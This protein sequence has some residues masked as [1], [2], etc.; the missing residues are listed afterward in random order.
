MTSV[1]GHCPMGSDDH[2]FVPQ[3]DLN[4]FI[5]LLACQVRADFCIIHSSARKRLPL[6]EVTQSKTGSN[7]DIAWRVGVC[8]RKHLGQL[9]SALA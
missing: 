3:P 6:L 9:H 2:R 1:H 4:A 8:V 7:S 5:L